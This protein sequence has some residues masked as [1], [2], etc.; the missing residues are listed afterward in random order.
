MKTVFRNFTFILKKFKTSSI[1]NI[2]G[3][4]VALA[5]FS[6]CIIQTISDFTYNHNFKNINST[7]L[8]TQYR[9]LSPKDSY[10]PWISTPKAQEISEKFPEVKNYCL[11]IANENFGFDII[12]DNGEKMLLRATLNKTTKGFVDVFTPKVL[13]GNPALVFSGEKT[14]K[15]MLSQSTAKTLFGEEDPLGKSIFFHNSSEPITVVAICDDFP[16]NCTIQNGVFVLLPEDIP[17]NFNYFGYFNV[18]PENVDKLVKRLNSGEF[19]GEESI[20]Q[21]KADPENSFSADL[22]PLDRIHL[23]F[24]LVGEGSFNT[25]ISLMAI[26]IVILIMAYINY[27]NFSIAIAPARVRGINIRKILG[28][29]ISVLRF[30]IIS[31]AVIFSL[32][33]YGLAILYIHIFNDSALSKSLFTN[34]SIS[35]NCIQIIVIGSIVFGLSIL[36]GLYPSYYVT[37]IHPVIAI[38]NSFANSQKSSKLRNILICIQF[39]C[40]ISLINIASF[41][42]IQHSYIKNYPSGIQKENIVYMTTTGLKTDIDT[43]GKE[44][45]LNKDILDYTVSGFLPGYVGMGWDRDF[46]GKIIKVMSW[47]VGRNFLRFFGVPVVQGRDF[48]DTEE[49]DTPY[50]IVNQEFINKYKFND[51]L[52]KKIFC[53][54]GDG[55]II[56]VT[57]N[58]NFESLHNPIRPMI[59]VRLNSGWNSFIFL[60]ISGNN[61]SQTMDYI[62]Q[63]WSKYNDEVFNCKFLNSR[64]DGLY[65]KENNLAQAISIISVITIL[66]AI[67]GIYGLII[68]NTR[69][70]AKE[71]A[72]RK[73]NGSSESNIV[74]LLNN[75]IIKLL[76]IAFIISTPLS[77]YIVQQWLNSF[78][79]ST[80]IYWWVFVLSG[81]AVLLTTIA[82]T[83]GQSIKAARKN[84]VNYLKNE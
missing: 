24:P 27:I 8:F 2:L 48:T 35:D 11:Y 19:Y 42:S 15:A 73:V 26:G 75:N 60:K 39:I 70:R 71:I 32:I 12:Q 58:I 5:I 72:I 31:E 76:I 1:L 49:S 62:K 69:Y 67:M 68:F 13:S 16:K 45:T 82:T 10:A 30:S 56:G 22:I 79:Y 20:K 29:K 57:K 59:F 64:L 50:I 80:P 47:P 81:I 83:C 4:S 55:E 63:C 6:A 25:T 38:K 23:H 34:L 41:I 36:F 43:F 53:F 78:A 46:E 61:T 18:D 51:I 74:L 52:G 44:L 33:A 37:S 77:Y 14:T 7:F 40:S 21:F 84:P 3:L 66:I 54:E 17:E 9:T 28:A 65:K